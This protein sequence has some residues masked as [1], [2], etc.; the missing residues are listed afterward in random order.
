MRVLVVNA[1]SS[2]LKLSLIG[3]DDATLAERELSAPRS[4]VDPEELRSALDGGLRD[5]EVVGHRIV[6]GGTRFREAVPIDAEVEAELRGLV[7]LAPLHQPKSLESLDAVSRALPGVPAVACFDTAFHATLPPE[8]STYALPRAWRERWAARRYGFHGLSHAWIARRVPDLLGRDPLE[9][10]IVSCHLGAGASLC[11]IGGGQS[12]DTTMGFT[13]LEGLVMATRSGSV[14]PG[15]LL[16]LLEQ[17][18]LEQRELARALEHESG[19]LGLAGSADMREVLERAGA[20]DD[21]ARLAVDVY[22]HRLGAGIAAMAAALGGL[23]ALAFTGG[24]GERSDEIRARA[25]ER[26][27][28]LGA[29]IDDRLNVAARLDCEIGAPEAAVR[30]LAI[31]AREDLEISAQTR[32]VMARAVH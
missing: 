1:G 24:V 5:A 14:D 10:R 22:V 25:V 12:R 32:R 4:T 17:T 26:A 27:G 21:A 16:W 15:L 11:A 28:F 29:A 9:L 31:R 13:P 30:V 8:A 19:L 3:E 18:G 20:H 23:D 7:S 6:H 2:S